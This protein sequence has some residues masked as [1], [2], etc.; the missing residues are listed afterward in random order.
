M[1]T[2][3]EECIRI[4]CINVRSVK[5]KTTHLFDCITSHNYDIFAICETWL[6]SENT[7]D[8][9]INVLLPP[10]YTIHHIDIDNEATGS[11]IAII[12]K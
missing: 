10:G 4:C 7:L 3:T 9:Y 5:N 1:N 11:G 8:V 2:P 12:Y 6:N